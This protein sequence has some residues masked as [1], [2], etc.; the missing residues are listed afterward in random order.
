LPKTSRDKELQK[1]LKTDRSA[2]LADAV[3]SIRD[4]AIFLLDP[5]GIVMTW[6]AGAERIKGYKAREIIGKHFSQ[7][8]PQEDIKRGYPDWELKETKKLG[9]FEDEGWRLRK[10]GTRFWANVVISKLVDKSGN[11]VGFSKVT[12]D[13]SDRRAAEEALRESEQRFRLLVDGVKDYAIFMMDPS[14]HIASWNEGAR[15]IKGY[16]QSEILGK[17]FSVFYLKSDIESGK[18]EYE[19]KEAE[20]TGRFEDEGWRLRK[21]GT[22]LWANVVITSIRDSEN[23][24]LGFSKVTRDL[25]ERRRSEE[26]LQRAYHEL[27]KRVVDRTAELAAANASLKNRE[28]ELEEAVKVRD[29]F[30]SIASHELKTPITSLKMQIQ[31]LRRK[32]DSKQGIGPSLDKLE[33]SLDVS[34]AQVDRLTQ[35]VEDLLDVA[36]AQA[37]KLVYHFELTDLSALVRETLAT[38]SEQ[39][40]AAGCKVKLD[41]PRPV[42]GNFDRFRLEQ[43]VVNLLTN[44]MKYASDSKLEVSV[45]QKDGIAELIVKDQGPGI[46]ADR[47]DKIFGRFERATSS[48]NISG[49]GLGL[50]I[51]KQIVEGHH[52]NIRVESSPGEG[53]AFIVELP[54]N[55]LALTHGR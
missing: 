44:A 19:L 53:A 33:S 32:T 11:L 29:E 40:E 42:T 39:L 34:L 14:G 8:Y 25:T 23:R 51:V 18:C 26:R 13:L 36:R 24:L 3:D 37:Q 9:R 27:E 12:R 45:L 55:M 4:Y 20:M 47:I 2:L 1:S 16:E 6:N 41:T 38:H 50:F 49:L 17:H 15:R 21:D 30:L 31:I 43:V 46:P 48:R 52:G 35:L 10:D 7:F 28:M 5:N 54:L 22:R